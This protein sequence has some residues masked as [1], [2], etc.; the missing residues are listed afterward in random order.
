MFIVILCMTTISVGLPYHISPLR[1]SHLNIHRSQD[2]YSY[3]SRFHGSEE[4]I[5]ISSQPAC[6]PTPETNDSVSFI[7]IILMIGLFS[8]NMLQKEI[9]EP[10]NVK[11][12]VHCV[13]PDPVRKQW[14]I[15]PIYFMS[16]F[17]QA[18]TYP[19]QSRK[20]FINLIFILKR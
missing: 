15:N 20:D 9:M 17:R 11:Y 6:I 2:F 1:C 19:L 14:K 13:S 5:G 8:S 12:V 4:E 10:T 16:S 3:I 7:L 18:N